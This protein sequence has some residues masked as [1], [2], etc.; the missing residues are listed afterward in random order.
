MGRVIDDAADSDLGLAVDQLFNTTTP[1]H[2]HHQLGVNA[3]S[4][5]NKHGCAPQPPRALD[6]TSIRATP[7]CERIVYIGRNACRDRA[8]HSRDKSLEIGLG[9][10][11]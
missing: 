1:V 5:D 2:S 9:P 4:P 3:T 11:T 6:P 7:I 8:T 10:S